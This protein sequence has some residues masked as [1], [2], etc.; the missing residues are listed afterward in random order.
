VSKFDHHCNW[1]NNCV[2]KNNH[3]VFYV[4][5]VSLLIYFITLVFLS[6]S[7]NENTLMRDD[8]EKQYSLL[9]EGFSMLMISPIQD[10]ELAN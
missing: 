2:G 8:L 3:L 9:G 5:I 7:F 4:Y 10:L 1:I 6:F